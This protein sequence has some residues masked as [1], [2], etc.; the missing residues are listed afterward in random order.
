MPSRRTQIRSAIRV[1]GKPLEAA[2]DE[3][4]EL[5]SEAAVGGD[6]DNDDDDDDD[7]RTYRGRMGMRRP[8]EGMDSMDEHEVLQSMNE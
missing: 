1:T 3:I 8:R 2:D 7:Q 6:N 5:E 4:P